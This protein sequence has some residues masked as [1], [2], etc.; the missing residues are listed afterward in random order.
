MIEVV[1]CLVMLAVAAIYTAIEIAVLV[2]AG[3]RR[4]AASLIRHMA[5]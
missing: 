4:F 2:A 5:K 3:L 1:G